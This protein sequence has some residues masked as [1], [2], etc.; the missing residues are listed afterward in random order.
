MKDIPHHQSMRTQFFELKYTD[1]INIP[2]DA[3]PT[4]SLGLYTHIERFSDDYVTR[5]GWKLAG[6]N[7]FKAA[8]FNFNK[9]TAYACNPDGTMNA[10]LEAAL[11]LEV[12]DGKTCA[13]LLQMMDDL[14]NTGK[15]FDTTFNQYFNRNNYLTWLATVILLGN[16]DTT[17]QNFALYQH[18]DTGKF[19]FL[20]WDYDAALDFSRQVNAS[21]Y[22]DWAYGVGNWWD[23]SLHRRFMSEPGNLKLLRD[24][25]EEIR[26]KHLTQ[27]AIRKLINTYKPTVRPF[28]TRSPDKDRLPGSSDEAQWE[29][30]VDR[31]VGTI[32]KN[33]NAFLESLK[34]PMPFWTNLVTAH[35][36]SITEIRWTWPTAF[37]PQGNPITYRIEFLPFDAADTSLPA[38]QTAFD[39]LGARTVTTH[40]LGN[41]TSFPGTSL[42][43]G[44][45][46]IRIFAQDATNNTSTHAFDSSYDNNSR[47]GVVCRVLPDNT[48]CPG[49]S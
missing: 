32:D 9:K 19:Y 44:A 23:S 46:W 8:S 24:A 3:G 26:E 36:N 11:E 10:D 30:E 17:T 21:S 38:S 22:A 14:S 18:P 35:D 41:A 49:V 48:K 29:A 43:S 16:Y 7:V 20:P 45:H 4:G 34:A 33:Y 40:N 5:R 37:H 47:F 2:A 28:V 13:S 6:A 39:A 27:D 42:P 25:V 12:G 31:L 15:A 1:S